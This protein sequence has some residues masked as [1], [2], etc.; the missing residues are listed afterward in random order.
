MSLAYKE[1]LE[2]EYWLNLLHDTGYIEKQHY[3]SIHS[4]ADELSRIL[5]GIFKTTR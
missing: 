1:G 5:F 2:T 3:D 4:C